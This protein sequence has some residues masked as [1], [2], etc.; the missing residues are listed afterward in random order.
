MVHGGRRQR[1]F[2]H[3]FRRSGHDVVDQMTRQI[4]IEATGEVAVG[5][6]ADQMPSLSVNDADA[7]DALFSQN[8]DG[9]RH[10]GA[11]RHQRHILADRA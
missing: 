2:R 3:G 4:A 8:L 11:E 7:A 9:A 5:E 6:D 10:R 1:L